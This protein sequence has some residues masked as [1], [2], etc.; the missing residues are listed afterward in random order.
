MIKKRKKM[1]RYNRSTGGY[2][3]DLYCNGAYLCSTDRHKRCKDAIERHMEIHPNEKGKIT[4]LFDYII[5][6]E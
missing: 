6:Y 1:K 5:Y 4:A 3:I 2:K